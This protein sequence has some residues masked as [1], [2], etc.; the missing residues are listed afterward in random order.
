MPIY[1][2]KCEACEHI[3]EKLV[4][5]SDETVVCP[6]CD[7]MKTTKLMSSAAFIGGSSGGSSGVSCSSG[8][9]SGFS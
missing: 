4:L 2:Y 5:K 9:A 1:E 7:S 6:M 8:G 3:F